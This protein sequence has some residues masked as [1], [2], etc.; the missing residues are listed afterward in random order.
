MLIAGCLLSHRNTE[1]KKKVTVAYL[2]S[3]QGT[4]PM[5]RILLLLEVSS[6]L[7]PQTDH[8]AALNQMG[9]SDTMPQ[10]FH[11]TLKLFPQPNLVLVRVHLE[12]SEHIPSTRITTII[13]SLL[14]K[15]P[16]DDIQS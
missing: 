6:L 1:E 14:A 13:L 4:L 8:K 16:P 11:S 5:V 2:F 3:S 9:T 15:S 10:N 7:W 12:W